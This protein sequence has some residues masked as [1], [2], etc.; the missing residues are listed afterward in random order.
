MCLKTACFFRSRY[1][2]QSLEFR[3]NSLGFRGQGI[4]TVLNDPP[5]DRNTPPTLPQNDLEA[6]KP[7]D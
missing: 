7:P 6:P 5:P 4:Y 3:V 1:R 2:V